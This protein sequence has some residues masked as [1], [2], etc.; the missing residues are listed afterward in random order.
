MNANQQLQERLKVLGDAV[1]VALAKSGVQGTPIILSSLPE[2]EKETNPFADA[3]F[4]NGPAGRNI[5]IAVGL[6]AARPNSPLLLIMSADSVTL[7]T[8]HLIHAARRNIGMTLLLLRRE[9]IF[10]GDR[11]EA[12][13]IGWGIPELQESVE[14]RGTPLEW[15]SALDA[16]FTGRGS[17][18]DPEGLAEIISKAILCPGF[19][20]VG[21]IGDTDLKTGVLNRTEW[22]EY[23]SAY[24]DWIAPFAAA[25]RPR[26]AAAPAPS[27]RSEYVPRF[28]IR[29]SGLG[30]HGIKLAGTILSEAAGLHEGLAV[31]QIGDYGSATRGGASTV[32]IV[33]GSDS[34]TYPGAEKANILIALTQSA[35]DR[36][37]AGISSDGIIITDSDGVGSPPPRSISLPIVSAAREAAGQ[38]V[39]AGVVSLGCTAAITRIIS[40][41]SFQQSIAHKVPARSLNGNQ[42]AFESGY[43]IAHQALAGVCYE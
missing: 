24:R 11:G 17:L 8:N 14:R 37:A 19:A 13:R 5:S 29:I 42:A 18:T 28:A 34:I 41:R 3:A 16:S 22:P 30:G 21:I 35:A 9:V 23:F 6:R 39:A 2:L 4:I 43:R 40:Q 38:P 20:I 32:D 1:Y 25:F 26:P 31:T 7:G 10:G 36:F 15:V 33:V 12:D 27:A